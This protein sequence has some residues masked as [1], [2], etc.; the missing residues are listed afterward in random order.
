MPICCRRSFDSSW[1]LW[2]LETKT[3][4]LHQ[5][6][7]S[8]AVY[9]I[10]FHPDGSV[11]E[12]AHSASL[13]CKRA[14]LVGVTGRRQ[15]MLRAP[16]CS[17]VAAATAAAPRR[18]HARFCSRRVL[19]TQLAGTSSLDASARLWDLRTGRNVLTLQGHVKQVLGIDFSPNGYHLA[20]GSDDHSIRLWDIRAQSCVYTLPAHKSLISEVRFHRKSFSPCPPLR[21]TSRFRCVAVSFPPSV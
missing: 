9:G 4:V 11:R 14:M 15:R 12:L 16:S 8:N 17:C 5:E 20:T 21:L 19:D 18:L 13:C 6:G 7:H 1:R 3:E 2:D 10:A